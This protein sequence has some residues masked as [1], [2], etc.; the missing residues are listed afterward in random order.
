MLPRIVIC[1]HLLL[2]CSLFGQPAALTLQKGIDLGL[3]H[4]YSDAL[5]LFKSVTDSFPDHPAGPLFSA[6]IYQSMMLDMETK[7]W[8]K[9]FAQSI[10]QALSLAKGHQ[11]RWYRFYRG[12][13]LSYKSYQQVRDK[14]YLAALPTAL[15]SMKELNRLVAEDSLF[16]EPVLGL[17]N[18]LYWRSKIIRWLPFLPQ[19]KEEGIRMI[20]KAFQ[21]ALLSKWAALSSLCWISIE[22]KR[23]EDAVGYSREGLAKFP[24]SRFFLWPLAEALFRAGRFNEAAA[25]YE[26]LKD[27]QTG[28]LED[29]GYNRVVILWKL[30]QCADKT[31][32]HAQVIAYSQQ[33][34][35]VAIK[36]DVAERASKKLE[37]CRLFLQK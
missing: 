29:N 35:H 5:A 36:P 32:E 7:Q 22:E 17:G 12:A 6:A 4:R 37:Q 13:A 21:R 9:E 3:E 15:S 28:L 14:N 31:G 11:D 20:E 2:P 23:Y 34:L 26:K 10:E 18:Y 25:A 24:E 8:Q 16:Y 33:A 27:S 1:C 19:Q 30:A